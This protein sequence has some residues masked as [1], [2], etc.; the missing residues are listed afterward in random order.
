MLLYLLL[1]C[2]HETA[3]NLNHRSYEYVKPRLS[4]FPSLP[5]FCIFYFS[6]TGPETNIPVEDGIF[7]LQDSRSEDFGM[8]PMCESVVTISSKHPTLFLLSCLSPFCSRSTKNM[9]NRM[10]KS[11][12]S[13]GLA[14]TSRMFRDLILLLGCAELSN[15]VKPSVIVPPHDKRSSGDTCPFCLVSLRGRYSDVCPLL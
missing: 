1:T 5:P 12:T 2:S 6:S 10:K 8:S 11:F 15:S 4:F 9:Q 14:S 3:K 13:L 7:A